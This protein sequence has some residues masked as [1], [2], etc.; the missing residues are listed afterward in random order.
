[1]EKKDFQ[2]VREVFTEFRKSVLGNGKLKLEIVQALAA[3]ITEYDV[4]DRE[5]R[6]IVGGAV[7]HIIGSAMRASGIVVYNRGQRA[8]NHDIELPSGKGFSSKAAFQD[9]P[10]DI[11][12]KNFLGVGRGFEWETA[13]ILTVSTIGIGYVDPIYFPDSLRH[14]GDASVLPRGVWLPFLNSHSELIISLNIPVNPH[15][16][17]TKR[18]S[19]AVADEILMR[20][21]FKLLRKFRTSIVED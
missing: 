19:Y 1:L 12:I 21:N 3:L 14:S 7:E 10:P 9:T 20:Q 16:P 11:R 2:E 6:F 4:A 18:A 17:S 8:V 5:N 15:N 13:T